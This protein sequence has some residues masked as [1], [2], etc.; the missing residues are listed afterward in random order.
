MC[1]VALLQGP[2]GH[3]ILAGNRDEQRTRKRALPP[4]H[5]RIQGT[6]ALMPI[7]AD[8]GGTWIGVNE[9]GLVASILNAYEED[10]WFE[11][12][13]PVMSRGVILQDM[14]GAHDPEHASTLLSLRQRDLARTRA[15]QVLVAKAE[16]TWSGFIARWDGR[17]LETRPI[18]GPEL[19]ISSGMFLSQVRVARAQAL[20]QLQWSQ[21]DE[22]ILQAFA[23]VDPVSGRPDALSV[24]MAREDARTVSHT[25]IRVSPGQAQITYLDGPPCDSPPRHSQQ[26]RLLA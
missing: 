3:L 19:L 24:C 18:L 25:L 17:A 8:A 6:L 1:T 7:D 10:A 16:P 12:A 20:S 13:T 21:D 5:V 2:A 9:R 23:Q 22:A 11:P 14:L 4:S 26:L 15:F